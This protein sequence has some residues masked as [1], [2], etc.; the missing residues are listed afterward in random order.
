MRGCFPERFGGRFFSGAGVQS[1]VVAKG[2]WAEVYHFHRPR[3]P[4]N[5][6]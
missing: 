4:K 1:M 2:A 5:N 6:A 3:I